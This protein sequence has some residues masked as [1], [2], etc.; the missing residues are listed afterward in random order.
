MTCLKLLWCLTIVA[1]AAKA[2]GLFCFLQSS[3]FCFKKCIY[4]QN[5]SKLK[6]IF[7][8]SFLFQNK[9]DLILLEQ[10]QSNQRCFQKIY[11]NKSQVNKIKR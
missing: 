5:L 8:K 4:Y 6:M 1:A 7:V 9:Q 11:T 3:I 10:A 2:Q